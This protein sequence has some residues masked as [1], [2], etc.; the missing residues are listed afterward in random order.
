MAKK[1][2]STIVSRICL[3]FALF[4]ST[5][6]I[7]TDSPLCPWVQ[8]EPAT[9]SSV[10]Q[11]IAMMMRKGYIPYRGTFDHKGPLTYIINYVGM[12]ISPNYGIWCIEFVSLAIT[13]WVMYKISCLLCT[14]LQACIVVLVS[15]FPLY[16]YFQ[17][18]NLVEEYAMP[19][20]AISA[21][22]F[23]DYLLNEIITPARLILCG[24]CM[25]GVLMLR[26]NMISLWIVFCLA[27]FFNK[28]YRKQFAELFHFILFFLVG[29]AIA[30]VPFLIWLGVNHALGDFWNVYIGFNFLY[31]NNDDM[32]FSTKW[33]TLCLFANNIVFLFALVSSL[34][35][36]YS[37][38]EK[39]LLYAAYS[40][41]LVVTLFLLSMS[42]RYYLHYAMILV[43]AFA[44]P[45]A[46]A[47][48]YCNH[49]EKTGSFLL[50]AFL[51]CSVGVS[52]WI[53][54]ISKLPAIYSTRHDN[55]IVGMTAE[56]CD[57]IAANT[58]PDDAIS[59]YG[60]W[61][62]LYIRTNRRHATKYSY[63]SPLTL[64][65]DEIDNEYW[66]QLKAEQPA[67]IVSA[68]P[69]T[70]KTELMNQFVSENGY[71][72]IWTDENNATGITIYIK[73]S[74]N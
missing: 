22:I 55:H 53:A 11:A 69:D 1:S 41:Y 44:F 37:N 45:I 15:L 2:F 6:I 10:F 9:D 27:I 4:C 35:F 17:D 21:F 65:S 40:F 7:L 14:R 24:F 16:D 62:F 5:F 52:P 18:G 50:G 43:P 3:L 51:L 58:S 66:Q 74:T 28:L 23:L 30:T 12:F 54:Q 42:G 36:C 60:N 39:R 56:I 70:E 63:Q 49:T 61:D 34:F 48:Q 47:F 57:V 67:L 29:T 68:Y 33:E 25:G 32:N 38:K 8:K 26:P 31:S 72:Q 64:V 19:L 71:T 13:V 20:I 73:D 46:S 59:V